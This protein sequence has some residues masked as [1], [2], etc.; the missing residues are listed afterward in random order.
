MGVNNYILFN[1]ELDKLKAKYSEI[2]PTPLCVGNIS[3]YFSICGYVNDF[4]VDY[5][6]TDLMIFWIFI[7]I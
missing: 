7:N 6:R 1:G 3:K 4:S 5:N 2:N